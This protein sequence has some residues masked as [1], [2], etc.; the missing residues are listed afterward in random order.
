MPAKTSAYSL[1]LWWVLVG[2]MTLTAA[3]ISTITYGIT[4]VIALLLVPVL[5]ARDGFPAAWRER[6]QQL[7]AI[8]FVLLGIAYAVTA[9]Q[10]QDILLV[11]NFA[12]MIFAASV[13]VVARRLSGPGTIHAV[14]LLC[15][16]GVIIAIGWGLY[17][18]VIQQH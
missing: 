9:R 6:F 17:E 8:A 2:A 18:V 1:T 13:Y 4:M 14:L 10:P 7:F 3:V 12:P 16:F 11:L 5:F 15:L